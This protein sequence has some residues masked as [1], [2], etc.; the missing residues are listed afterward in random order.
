M[1]GADLAASVG[2]E[3]VG[4]NRAADDLVNVLGL[5]I[6]A[7]DFLVLPV[8]KFRRDKAGMAGQGAE[9]V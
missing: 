1:E 3:L 8:G 9:L 6:L 2:Q 4:T 7:V 5:L